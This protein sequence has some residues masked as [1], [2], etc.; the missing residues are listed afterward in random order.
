MKVLQSAQKGTGRE[1]NW[2]LEKSGLK[3]KALKPQAS[4]SS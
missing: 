4:R 3:H 2:G 1:E